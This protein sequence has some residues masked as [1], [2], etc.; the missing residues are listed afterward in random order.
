VIYPN[1]LVVSGGAKCKVEATEFGI[2]DTLEKARRQLPDDRPGIVFVK[3]PPKWMDIPHFGDTCVA[4]ARDFL[5][6]TRRVVSV[7]YYAA[8]LASIDGMTRIQHAF[9]EVSNPITDFGNFQN[10]DIFCMNMP[11]EWN[12]MPPWWQRIMFYPDGE[13]R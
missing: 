7:K 13:V 5:R 9:M 6:T 4:V 1:G 3:V 11:A 12:G 10:W 2:D 8:P